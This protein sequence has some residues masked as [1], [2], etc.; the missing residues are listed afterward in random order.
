MQTHQYALYACLERHA[1]QTRSVYSQ[2]RAA[3]KQ[4][5]CNGLLD[6]ALLSGVALSYRH[7]LSLIKMWKP[8][9][10]TELCTFCTP[11]TH[12]HCALIDT[13]AAL[14]A[15]YFTHLFLCSLYNIRC[16][17]HVGLLFLKFNS[18]FLLYLKY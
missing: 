15:S 13:A 7:I 2:G 6:C 11:H 8:P 12:T 5:W 3:I 4:E 1:A 16:W 14:A 18:T 9:C 10:F 17:M